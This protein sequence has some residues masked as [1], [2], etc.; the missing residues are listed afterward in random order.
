M[1]ARFATLLSAATLITGLTGLAAPAAAGEE[2]TAPGTDEVKVGYD[3]GFY[4]HTPD[5]SL[6]INGRLQTRFTSFDL[7]GAE[8]GI[9]NLSSFTIPRARISFG[10]HLYSPYVRYY[11]EYDLRGELVVTRV[12]PDDDD[13]SGDLQEDEIEVG[14]RQTAGLRW[15]YIDFTKYALAQLRVGQMKVPFG[16]QELTSSGSQQFVERSVASVAFSPSYDQGVQVSGRTKGKNFG[17]MGG[18]FNGNGI[19][20]RNQILNNNEGFRYAARVHF[21][22]AGEYKLE[23]SAVDHPEKFNWT[24][25]AAWTRAADDDAAELDATTLDYFFAF[26]YRPLS[27]TAEWF[28]R[29]QENSTGPD[30]DLDGYIAQAGLFVVPRRLE[31]ALRRSE[32]DPDSDVDDNE[33]VESRVGV[34]WFFMKHNFKLQLDYGVVTLRENNE[35]LLAL[36][37]DGARPGLSVGDEADD[38]EFRAQLQIRF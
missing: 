23:E 20:S 34:N 26:K 37:A 10:G 14:T 38:K 1:R 25:G 12:R 15:G 11:I 22:P 17:Y 32:V 27:F 7:D 33:V 31:V 3:K 24:I 29:S 9:D 30:T 28:E 2:T 8:S 36:I 6:K 16:N 21:D 35:A 18:A 13:A 5:F 19:V 4:I